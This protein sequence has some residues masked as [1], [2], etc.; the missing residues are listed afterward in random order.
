MWEKLKIAPDGKFVSGLRRFNTFVLVCFAWIFFR[1]NSTA[2]LPVIIGKLFTDWSFGG[3]FISNSLNSMGL[4]LTAI[5][6]CVLSLVIL[7]II[8]RSKL[9]LSDGARAINL[10]YAYVVWAIAIAW[11]L[12][13]AG[14]GASSFI[15]FQF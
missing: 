6:T 3:E 4:D 15:Y 1:A 8:D 11:V 10:R 7:W 13:L 2:D 5:I 9:E 12:L 14:D